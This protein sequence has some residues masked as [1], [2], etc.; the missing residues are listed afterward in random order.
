[1]KYNH[2]YTIAFE[3][4]SSTPTGEDVTPEMLREALI[5]RISELDKT[6]T[7]I[8]ATGAPFDTFEED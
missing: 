8:E 4:V 5:R 7:W 6:D 3:L 1:M 2:A